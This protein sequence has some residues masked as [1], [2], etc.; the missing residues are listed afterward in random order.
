MNSSMKLS[1]TK[2]IGRSA[3]TPSASVIARQPEISDMPPLHAACHKGSSAE[4]RGLVELGEDVNEQSQSGMTPLMCAVKVIGPRNGDDRIVQYLLD[5]KADVNMTD[6]MGDTALHISC[7]SMEP[8][9]PLL[10]KGFHKLVTMLLEGNADPNIL[11]RVGQH[12]MYRASQRG[13]HQ[14]AELLVAARTDL[15][16]VD[17]CGRTVLDVAFDEKM[18]AILTPEEEEDAEAAE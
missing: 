5:Q 16:I 1:M 7:A 10:P 15:S 12:A 6:V 9:N 4:A 17:R 13:N 2:T 11:N 8:E 18:R 14:V 3:Q